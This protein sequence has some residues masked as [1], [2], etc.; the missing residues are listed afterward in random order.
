MLRTVAWLLAALVLLFTGVMGLYNGVTEWPGAA[1]RWQQ[2]VSLGVLLYGV[3]GLV[4]GIGL[5]LRRAWSV[6]W[7]IAW[8]VVVTYVAAAAVVA[9]GGEGFG[10]AAVAGVATA[11]IG[12]LVVAATR[13]A[14]RPAIREPL[15]NDS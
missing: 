11:L 6:R 5:L 3:L 8:A 10:P 1:T 15:P 13:H 14:V 4:A 2:S 9:Y 7:A 12:W